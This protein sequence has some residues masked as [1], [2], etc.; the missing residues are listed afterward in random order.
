MNGP[1]DG[2]PTES[3]VRTRA[4]K[5]AGMLVGIL[6]ELRVL[7]DA[8]DQLSPD[9]ETMERK[10]IEYAAIHV[11]KALGDQLNLGLMDFMGVQA[12]DRWIDMAVEDGTY[13]VGATQEYK[14]Y[15]YDRDNGSLYSAKDLNADEM[16]FWHHS[17]EG[18]V[19]HLCVQLGVPPEGRYQLAAV[20]RKSGPP[21]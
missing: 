19:H 9:E 14:I 4:A 11:R 10:V 1:D 2:R 20:P 3:E 13:S 8:C 18:V 17:V 21:A 5:A 7:Q 12:F 15:R 6:H 16:S